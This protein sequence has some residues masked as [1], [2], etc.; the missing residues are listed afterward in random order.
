MK[1]AFRVDKGNKPKI[2]RD[3][4]A[5]VTFFVAPAIMITVGFIAY[6]AIM[7]AFYSLYEL[8]GASIS[9]TYVGLENW[10]RLF[11]DPIIL[12][13]IWHT[14]FLIV[15]TVFIEIPIAFGIA[16]LLGQGKIFGKNLYRT[17]FFFPVVL[18]VTVAGVLWSWVYNPQYGIIN[19]GLR[20]IGLSEFAKPWLAES[21]LV[22]SAVTFVIVWK[23]IGLYIVIFMAGLAS[24][25]QDIYDVAKLDGT[26]LWQQAVYV[27]APMLREV[28][29][30]A[31]AIGITASIKRF[32]L[33]Y[34]MTTG[35]PIH[36]SEVLAT[37]M[38]KQAFLSLDTGYAS[39]IAFFLFLLTL[40]LVVIQIQTMRSKEVIEF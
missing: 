11:S 13:C 32:D 7:S 17:A 31:V 12:E 19:E 24:I 14:L 26:N 4:P 5:L 2:K 37:Y 8:G 18:S 36:H 16:L 38:Y 23:W 20:A 15:V 34:I 9:R 25:P 27:V 33:I 29:V 40:G 21:R 39:T 6:P 28:F 35:G 22:L 1:F 30:V 3:H 10:K